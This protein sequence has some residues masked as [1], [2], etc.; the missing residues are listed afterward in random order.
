MCKAVTRKQVSVTERKGL[1]AG[2]AAKA[3]NHVGH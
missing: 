1:K 3:P 2:E